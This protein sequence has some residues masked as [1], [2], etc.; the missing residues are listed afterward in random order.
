MTLWSHPRSVGWR[1]AALVVRKI[2]DDAP[3][4][5]AEVARLFVTVDLRAAQA[6]G[7]RVPLGMLARA[8]AVR[9]TR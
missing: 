6:A 7:Y 4:E 5:R 1:L 2:R 8:D 9:G 3:L